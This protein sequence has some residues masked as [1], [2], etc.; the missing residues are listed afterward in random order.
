L[1]EA[2]SSD[3]GPQMTFSLSKLLISCVCEV[4]VSELW[5]LSFQKEAKSLPLCLASLSS[6]VASSQWGRDHTASSIDTSSL[7]LL[8]EWCLFYLCLW[9]QVVGSG[10]PGV[11]P[12]AMICPM[13]SNFFACDLL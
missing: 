5:C 3:H 12:V 2:I 6:V 8:V 10:T 4:R 13:T 9:P 11:V 1:S 7:G